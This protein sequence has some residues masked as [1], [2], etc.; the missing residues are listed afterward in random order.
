M[1]DLRDARI[2]DAVPDIVSRQPW[3]RAMSLAFAGATMRILD[4]ADASQIFT[5]IDKASEDVLDMLAV[6]FK[7]DWYNTASPIETKRQQIQQALQVRRT[8]GTAGALRQTVQTILPH[9]EL[10]EWF[11]TD[12]NAPPGTFELKTTDGL[13]PEIAEQLV[14]MV[15]YAKNVRSHLRRLLVQRELRC[16]AYGAVAVAWHSKTVITNEAYLES[17][18]AAGI[19]MASAVGVHKSITIHNSPQEGALIPSRIIAGAALQRNK[20]TMIGGIIYGKL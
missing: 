14:N 2:T 7:V 8:I 4:E 19:Y 11:Q 17:K 12:D 6:S 15:G 5:G 13:T 3:V 1:I 16:K 20:T 18:L 10:I 9:V